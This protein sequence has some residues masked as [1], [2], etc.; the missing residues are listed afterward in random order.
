MQ[1][2]KSIPEPALKRLCMLYR[3]LEDMEKTEQ[4]ELTSG[5]LGAKLNIPAHTVR[6]DLSFLGRLPGS[7]KGYPL[8]ALRKAIDRALGFSKNK[9]ACIAGIGKL[10]TALLNYRDFSSYGIELVAGFDSDINKLERL[11]SDIPLYPSYEMEE[12]IAERAIEIGIL[13]VPAQKAQVTA[14]KMVR[15]GIRGIVNFCP[16]LLD[17]EPCVTVRNIQMIEEFRFL[18]AVILL[19]SDDSQCIE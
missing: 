3:F 17:I 12:V 14:E 4:T 5:E 8:S 9:T 1:N 16:V 6:K 19:S 10:G 18:A 11:Q 7:P 2:R 15:G 13:A